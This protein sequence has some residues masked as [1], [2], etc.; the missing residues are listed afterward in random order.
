M[1]GA[2]VPMATMLAVVTSE[3]PRRTVGMQSIHAKQR[4]KT[5]RGTSWCV[6]R[7]AAGSSYTFTSSVLN[8]ARTHAEA[9]S[10]PLRIESGPISRIETVGE[11]WCEKCPTSLICRAETASRV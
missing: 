3:P 4:G 9:E 6:Y 7:L 10:K 5:G 2:N 11:K 8:C 1:N